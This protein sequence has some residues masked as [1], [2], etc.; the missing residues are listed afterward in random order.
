MPRRVGW[1]LSLAHWDLAN[2]A[3]QLTHLLNDEEMKRHLAAAPQLGRALRPLC[4][5]L[6]I[7]PMLLGL[8]PAERKKR[9]VEEGAATGRPRRGGQVM[10]SA[11]LA[12]PTI[13]PHSEPSRAA[14]KRAI[15]TRPWPSIEMQANP[16]HYPWYPMEPDG[17]G[18]GGEK[19]G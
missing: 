6:G 15:A 7:D 17:P 19:S 11:S 12:H 16:K 13:V 10:G 3:S 5:M 8:P 9:A 2:H 1:L 14:I 18:D 4:R